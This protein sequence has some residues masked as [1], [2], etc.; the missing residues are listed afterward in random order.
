MAALSRFV[1]LDIEESWWT[2]LWKGRTSVSAYGEQIEN[3][4]KTEFQPVADGLAETAERVLTTYAMTSSKWSFGLCVNII[5]AVT[6]R[7]VQLI[8][9]LGGNE[10]MPA[11]GSGDPAPERKQQVQTLSDRLKRC[12]ALNHQFEI[13]VHDLGTRLQRQPEMAQ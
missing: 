12:G 1:A 13:I 8:G 5:Q 4:I 9:K 6:R 7:R 10:R 3:L 2:S 11:A